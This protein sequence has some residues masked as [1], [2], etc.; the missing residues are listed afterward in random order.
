MISPIS[1]KRDEAWA[2]FEVQKL[3]ELVPVGC[4]GGEAIP[5]PPGQGV[6]KFDDGLVDL[7]SGAVRG[8][9]GFVKLV[10]LVTRKAF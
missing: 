8:V 7:H 6:C 5:E 3:V 2:V 10:K 4:E 9:P 1:F